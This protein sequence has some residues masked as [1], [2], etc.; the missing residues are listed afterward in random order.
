MILAILPTAPLLGLKYLPTFLLNKT[1]Y[2]L[3]K[4]C[5]KNDNP[6]W[7]DL[8]ILK[9]FFSSLLVNSC[10]PTFKK[11]NIRDFACKNFT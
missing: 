8:W 6:S 5:L 2:Y 3:P 9:D 11:A 1:W 7:I 10:I 4:F